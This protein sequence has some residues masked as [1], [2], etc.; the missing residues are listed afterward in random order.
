M[1]VLVFT[2]FGVGF[3]FTTFGV[4]RYRNSL[5][6]HLVATSGFHVIAT[7]SRFYLVATTCQ[8]LSTTQG[9]CTS[10]EKAVAM[11]RKGERS[12][13]HDFWSNDTYKPRRKAGRTNSLTCTYVGVFCVLAFL[14]WYARSAKK[15]HVVPMPRVPAGSLTKVEL[16]SRYHVLF[17]GICCV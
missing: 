8:T 14:T 5:R 4:S 12:Y 16:I 6:Y 13:T 15:L 3:T 17:V 10:E 9:C 11:L 2:R 1:C 7:A